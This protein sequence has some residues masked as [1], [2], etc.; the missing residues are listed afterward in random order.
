MWVMHCCNQDLFQNPG[1]DHS[2]SSYN[3]AALLMLHKNKMTGIFIPLLLLKLDNFSSKKRSGQRKVMMV[4]G[5]KC[6]L[7]FPSLV[8]LCEDTAVLWSIQ[9]TCFHLGKFSCLLAA[10]LLKEAE[11]L[12]PLANSQVRIPFF[13]TYFELLDTCFGH[14][15]C[16]ILHLSTPPVKLENVIQTL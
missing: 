15:S 2:L 3:E 12:K 1:S 10:M 14:I 8:S 6:Q 7:P 13:K 16:W 4:R 5:K 11:G 9:P